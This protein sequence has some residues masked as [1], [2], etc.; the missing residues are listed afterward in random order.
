LFERLGEVVG[1]L[2]QLGQQPGILDGDDGLIGEGPDQRNFLLAEDLSLVVQ[3]DDGPDNLVLPDH[4]RGNDGIV[5]EVAGKLLG[6]QRDNRVAQNRRV[7]HNLL[8]EHC[9]ATDRGVVERARIAL[10]YALEP[11]LSVGRRHFDHSVA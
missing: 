3:A 1:K 4:G 5:V 7:L 9:L 2:A 6:C 10:H 8:R 11:R